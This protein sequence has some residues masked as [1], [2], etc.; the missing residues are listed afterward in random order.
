[1]LQLPHA[2]G[3]H[4]R[5]LAA[6]MRGQGPHLLAAGRAVPEVH[7]AAASESRWRRFCNASKAGARTTI[8][9]GAATA[10]AQGEL[11]SLSKIRDG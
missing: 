2:L 5:E 8:R 7:A 4:P 10:L 1:M 3:G 9:P 11:E 6:D